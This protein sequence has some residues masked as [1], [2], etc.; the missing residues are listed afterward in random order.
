MGKFNVYKLDDGNWNRIGGESVGEGDGTLSGE[1]ISKRTR[2]RSEIVKK[3]EKSTGH[4]NGTIK[5]RKAS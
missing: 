3:A 5:V 1:G 2:N 4:K